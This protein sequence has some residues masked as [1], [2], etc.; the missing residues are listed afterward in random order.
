MNHLP[1][2]LAWCTQ[3][4]WIDSPQQEIV[5]V[6]SEV[7]PRPYRSPSWSWARSEHRINPWWPDSIEL[8]EADDEVIQL[9]DVIDFAVVPVDPCNIFGQ[10]NFACLSLQGRLAKC[11]WDLSEEPWSSFK[12]VHLEG[13]SLVAEMEAQCCFDGV[14]ELR[15]PQGEAR[16]LFL[17]IYLRL[18]FPKVMFLMLHRSRKGDKASY[19]RIGMGYITGSRGSVDSFRSI[20]QEKKEEVILI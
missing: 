13:Y 2:G 16:V 19:S 11:S 10:L 17:F 4:Y 12:A 1:L 20:S 9:C 6:T 8:N 7:S 18:K 5:D 14:A 15:S 3:S